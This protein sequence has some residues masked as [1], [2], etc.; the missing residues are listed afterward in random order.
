M[1]FTGSVAD[2][3]TAL[4]NL[5][6]APNLNYNGLAFITMTTNDL[7]ASGSGGAQTDADL[8]TIDVLP[9][10]D[11]PDGTDTTVTAIEDTPYA[12][13]LPNFGFNDVDSGEGDTMTDV[14]IDAISLPVGAT[15]QLSGT[16]VVAGQIITVADINA[17]NLVF[18][19]VPDANGPNYASFTFSVRDFGVPPGPLFD[20]VPN[21]MTIDV[22]PVNDLPVITSDGGLSTAAF[23][24]AEN[25][26]AVTTVTATDV[27]LQPLNYS[28][29][30]GADA[31]RFTIDAVTGVLAFAPAPNF[32]APTDAGS[33]NIYNVTVR[34]SDGFGGSDTQALTITVTDVDDAP[35]AL[36][37]AYATNEDTSL[38]VT[39]PG[40]LG[41]DYD[42]DGSPISATLVSGPSRG[43][44]AF[45]ADG[46]FVY[47]PDANFFGTDSF[48]YRV[49]D[50]SLQ[51]G[52]ATVTLT[53]NGIPDAP[54]SANGNVNTDE[55]VSYTFTLADFS[56]SDADGDP[57]DHI[58]I[59]SLPVDGTL[60]LGGTAVAVNDIVTVADIAAGNLTYTPP[61]SVPGPIADQFG[62]RVHDGTQYQ[63]GNQLMT[64][65]VAPLPVVA[66]PPP[67]G[68]GGTPPPPSTGGSDDS[69][70]GSGGDSGSGSASAGEAPPAGGG[71]SGSSSGGESSAPAPEAPA[72][73]AAQ[74]ESTDSAATLA[75]PSVADSSLSVRAG[76]IAAAP[77]DG[78]L[79]T[80]AVSEAT[81]HEKEAEEAAVAAISAPEFQEDLD[82]LRQENEAEA[83]GETRVA[84][85]VFAAS[86]S[87]SVGYVIWLLR[88]G[89]LLSSLLSSLPAWRL[90][91]PLPVLSRLSDGSDDD[92]D[93]S[94]EELVTQEGDDEHGDDD[95]DDA[96]A[97]EMVDHE[98]ARNR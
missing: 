29:S 81:K 28:I 65:G 14:R 85:T 75:A 58:E 4:N 45:N 63:A 23:V 86:T 32:E 70:S 18:T 7:G 27:D 37:D 95:A 44:L 56:Y 9:V 77:G 67:S 20:P 55:G 78:G 10:N 42:E 61:A 62:F 87:L 5:V 96:I 25:T 6:F 43:T 57:L 19:P 84:G 94:L 30:G 90:V 53:V 8:A 31:A 51:S 69:G 33:D 36:A 38:T 73:E 64:V 22:A 93:A 72:Q 16:D 41:N 79:G 98:T 1:R 82:K 91:D 92:D 59:T 52:N 60:M 97:G 40:A 50:G 48:V 13:T 66:P 35:F 21:T 88:G 39:A 15:L 80:P 49:S 46:S 89:V 3:N 54:T 76:G 2:I 71:R 11:A 24:L 83:T 68:G 17:G 47:T 74:V 34:V 26:T 12:F